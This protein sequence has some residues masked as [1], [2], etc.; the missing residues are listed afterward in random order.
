M[1]RSYHLGEDTRKLSFHLEYF[2][3]CGSFLCRPHAPLVHA[4]PFNVAAVAAVVAEGGGKTLFFPLMC[5]FSGCN[6]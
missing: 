4:E 1:R 6:N 5:V 2:F 3:F